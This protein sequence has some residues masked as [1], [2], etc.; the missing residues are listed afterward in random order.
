M[1]LWLILLSSILPTLLQA[2]KSAVDSMPEGATKDHIEGA[3]ALVI[4]AEGLAHA[5]PDQVSKAVAAAHAMVF[6]STQAPA[7]AAAAPAVP[8][9][10]RAAQTDAAPA[11]PAAAAP[12][13]PTGV[14][15]RAA[16]PAEF[17]A[18]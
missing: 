8:Q 9:L 2:V 10:H 7:A 4:A 11:A 14:V 13:V 18:A 1:P 5:D 3:V 6:G 15:T 17:S 16:D 12:V